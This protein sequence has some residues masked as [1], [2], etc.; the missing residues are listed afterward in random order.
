[1]L[2]AATSLS[3]MLPADRKTR[4]L[5]L[6]RISMADLD[7]FIDLETELR[8]HETPP[9]GAPERGAWTGYLKQFAR[10]WDDG[11]VGYWTIRYDGRVVGF[12]GVKPKRWRDRN[13]WNL[14]YRLWPQVTGLG[15]ATEMACEAVTVA[16]GQQPEW[17][18]LV[19]TRPPNRP[20]IAVAQRAGLTRRPDLDADGWVVLLLER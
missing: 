8:R 3:A 13:C 18:V 14:Y 7:A 19:E 1:M 10:V 2:C 20:A 11:Q 4:R 15:L 6:S 12:G 5:H 17:P 9:R 16:A